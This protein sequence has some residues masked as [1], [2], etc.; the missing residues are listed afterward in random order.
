MAKKLKST[1]PSSADNAVLI[2]SVWLVIAVL[3]LPAFGTQDQIMIP[4][5]SIGAII[6]SW[7]LCTKQAKGYKYLMLFVIAGAILI[8][9]ITYM[10]SA[11]VHLIFHQL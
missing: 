7:G 6:L 5:F 3:V 8:T 1:Q 11:F 4:F 10:L 2:G 9:V